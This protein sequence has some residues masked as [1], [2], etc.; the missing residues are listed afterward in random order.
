M[1]VAGPFFIGCLTFKN[2]SAQGNRFHHCCSCNKKLKR[3]KER[4]E[5]GSAGAN[6]GSAYFQP[7]ACLGQQDL[8]V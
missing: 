8:G 6:E 7:A 4:Q 5:R 3:D 1:A 2:R